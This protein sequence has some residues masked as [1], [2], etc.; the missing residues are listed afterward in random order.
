MMGPTNRTL[1]CVVCGDVIHEPSGDVP[2]I[3]PPADRGEY[4]DY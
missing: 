3:I 1:T 2:V 4:G